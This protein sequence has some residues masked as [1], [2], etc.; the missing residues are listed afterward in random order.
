M[1]TKND[2][3]KLEARDLPGKI[4]KLKFSQKTPLRAREIFGALESYNTITD[5]FEEG[6]ERVVLVL[7]HLPNQK[8]S[9]WPADFDNITQRFYIISDKTIGT[10]K[11]LR[12]DIVEVLCDKL[13]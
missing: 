8:F 1:E 5:Y 9:V 6:E 2:V 13:S 4:L 3:S 12:A 11:I 10:I 7:E